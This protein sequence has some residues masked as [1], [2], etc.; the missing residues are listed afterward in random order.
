MKNERILVMKQKKWIKA[1]GIFLGVMAALTV[2][3]RWSASVN[4]A[5][6]TL[7]TPQNLLITHKVTGSGLAE[8]TR[9]LAVFAK[10]N[11]LVEQLLVSQ[12]QAVKKGEKLLILSEDSIREAIRE[13]E[14]TILEL[15]EKITDLESQKVVDDNTREREKAYA[16][17][18]Y[19]QTAAGAQTEVDIA[20]SE[21]NAAQKKLDEFYRENPFSD[22]NQEYRDKEESL[23][24]ELR[25]K[26]DALNRAIA[27]YNQS[28]LAAEKGIADAVAEKA[29]DS[30][31]TALQRELEE[32]EE[33]QALLKKVLDKKGVVEAPED[34][35]VKSISAQTGSRT[36][37]EA[38]VLLYKS[39]E[40]LRLQIPVRKED[41]KYIAP[42]ASVQ[43]TDSS[44]KVLEGAFA[45]ALTENGEDGWVLTVRISG[46][47]AA[48]GQ[49]LTAEVIKEEGPYGCCVP[50]SAL[51]KENSTYFV[52]VAEP[53]NTVLGEELTVRKVVV[54]VENQNETIAALKGGS[55]SDMQKVVVE[56][57]KEISEGSRVRIAEQ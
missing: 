10:E 54:E 15:Q 52:Y 53:K 1:F 42:G 6:V 4:T 44:Q 47:L 39:G 16:S 13:Q 57:N 20:R 43:V 49:N 27:S 36:T 46:E 11:L 22:G 21:M 17:K 25:Q 12:G 30:T 5:A 2:F 56:T 45:E 38:A 40:S 7:Q 55:L 41:V 8:G 9:E 14:K 24:E 35:V 19:T 31:K 50:L 37:E 48:I 33:E 32:A 28:V 26:R 29:P 51:H 34:G 3:S 18:A 23:V